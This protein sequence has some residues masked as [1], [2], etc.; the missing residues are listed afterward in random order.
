MVLQPA[1]ARSALAARR[2]AGTLFPF[3]HKGFT[4]GLSCLF[5]LS[6]AKPVQPEKGARSAGFESTGTGGGEG[7]GQE[8][9]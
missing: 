8:L 7:R 3:P 9:L 5:V 6:A 4:F 1:G 2:Q